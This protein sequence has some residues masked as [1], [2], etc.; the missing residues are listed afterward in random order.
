M[1]ALQKAGK[2]AFQELRIDNDRFYLQAVEASYKRSAT[3]VKNI[4]FQ[5]YTEG[6]PLENVDNGMSVY[7]GINYKKLPHIIDWGLYEGG[8]KPIPMYKV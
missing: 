6:A 2:S 4:M 7:M 1:S 3:M 5:K 8:L